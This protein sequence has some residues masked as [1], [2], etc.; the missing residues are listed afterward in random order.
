[1]ELK[2]PFQYRANYGSIWDFDRLFP[3]Q[4]IPALP[5]SEERWFRSLFSL[6]IFIRGG[7]STKKM[8]STKK[9]LGAINSITGTIPMSGLK[10]QVIQ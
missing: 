5:V 6:F 4:K 1:V 10:V 7:A 9:R 2:L 3:A 8:K